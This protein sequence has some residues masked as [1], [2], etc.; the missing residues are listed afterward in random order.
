MPN[1]EGG[2]IPAHLMWIPVGARQHD[3]D[4]A[5]VVGWVRSIYA[6]GYPQHRDLGEQIV[7]ELARCEGACVECR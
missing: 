6:I 5:E 7:A 1:F 3:P 2:I 4:R